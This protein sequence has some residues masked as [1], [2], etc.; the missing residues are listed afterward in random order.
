MTPR[1]VRA[2]RGRPVLVTGHTGFKGSWL[3]LW[4]AALGARVTGYALPPAARSHFIAA[5]VRGRL[6]RHIEADLR[7]RAR[8]RRALAQAEPEVVFHL[9]AQA[10]VGDGYRRPRETFEVN[11]LGLVHLLEAVRARG[12]PCR[13]VVVTSDKCYELAGAARACREGDPL[14]GADPYA[15][16][17]A[18]QELACE[19][20]R[21]AFFP[22]TKARRHGVR[23]ASARSGNV[24]GGGDWAAG[25]LLPDA[26]RA[27]RA[28]RPVGVRHPDA[29]RPWQHVLEPLG[30]YLWL[31]ARLAAPQGGDCCRAW[32]FGPAHRPAVPVR[33]VVA[34]TVRWWGAGAWM[35]RRDP[36]APPEAALLAL[37]SRLARDRLGWF[38]T[39]DWHEAVRRTVAWYRAWDR[40]HPN[41][42]QL[43]LDE[44]AAFGRDARQR[45]LAWA[46]PA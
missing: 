5:R 38:P 22:P 19:A 3:A 9:A 1:L 6:A 18:A 24:I 12:R 41:L 26:I 15:A 17:K 31:A 10:L 45:G 28:G 35:P 36:C 2:F 11:V 25:R 30:G 23:L 37:D 16:S 21:C 46:Q 40:G 13:V 14:G 29:V 27:L 33:R 39:W 4:L 42:Q 34:E 8:L 44:I 32:N 20:W 43:S 7:D